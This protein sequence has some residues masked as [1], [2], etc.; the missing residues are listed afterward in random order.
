MPPSFSILSAVKEDVVRKLP[1]HN[2]D[3]LKAGVN[4]ENCLTCKDGGVWGYNNQVEVDLL[5]SGKKTIL[6]NGDVLW[7]YSFTVS[8][9]Y[10]LQLHFSRFLI[11]EGGELYVYNRDSSM[12]IRAL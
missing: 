4:E 5:K 7:K 9:A 10:A 2:V 11:P 1:E 3:S 12:V 6:P 8:Y